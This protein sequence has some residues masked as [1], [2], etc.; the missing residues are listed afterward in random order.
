M[1]IPLYLSRSDLNN[2]VAA[3]HDLAEIT[4]DNDYAVVDE[5]HVKYC[6]D[7]RAGHTSDCYRPRNRWRRDMRQLK[8]LEGAIE[9]AALAAVAPI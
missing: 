4:T 7:C 8:R 2:L 6:E 1:S 3:L 5:E 9:T